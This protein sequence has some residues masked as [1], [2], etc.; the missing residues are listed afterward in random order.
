MMDLGGGSGVMSMALLR[1]YPDLTA[2]VVD[3]P[4]VCEAGRLLVNELVRET[5][6]QIARHATGDSVGAHAIQERIAYHAADFLHDPLPDGFDLILECDVGIYDQELFQKL[7][8]AL[9]PGG[10]L[11]I[12]DQFSPE[13]GVAPWNPPYPQW[14]FLGS[15]EDPTSSGRP[16]AAEIESRLTQAGFRPVSCEPLP[17]GEVNRWLQ[18]WLVIQAHSQQGNQP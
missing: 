9:N 4:N 17:A 1:R 14:A 7:R 11:V 5:G 8:A 16:T 3:I 2:V 6:D 18:G 15:L 10:R 12:V 13:T